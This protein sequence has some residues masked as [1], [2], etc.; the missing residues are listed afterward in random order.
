MLH[1]PER[2]PSPAPPSPAMQRELE[3]GVAYVPC[4]LCNNA[5]DL[6][7]VPDGGR[8][9]ALCADHGGVSS[10]DY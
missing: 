8:G 2:T 7:D 5:V 1:P 6:M 4:A 10:R 3:H 9:L